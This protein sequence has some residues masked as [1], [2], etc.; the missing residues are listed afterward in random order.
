MRSISLSAAPRTTD[1]SHSLRMTGFGRF[2]RSNARAFSASFAAVLR[3]IAPRN[4]ESARES[5]AAAAFSPRARRTTYTWSSNWSRSSACSRVSPSAVMRTRR[6]S[7]PP[8]FPVPCWSRK[9]KRLGPRH[10]QT[11]E[12]AP[13]APP[14]ASCA[15]PRASC[16]RAAGPANSPAARPWAYGSPSGC[17]IQS[18]GSGCTMAEDGSAEDRDGRHGRGKT[19]SRG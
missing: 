10:R 16:R 19:G 4:G 12:S 8:H 3:E 9:N 13:N 17:K 7:T 6:A 18:A 5:P 1:P 15:Q 2:C 11:D 14:H